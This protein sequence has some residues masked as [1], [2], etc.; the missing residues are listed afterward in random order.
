VSPNYR[1]E[2]SDELDGIFKL[3]STPECAED[4]DV[5]LVCL[6]VLK[7]LSRKQENR[8]NFGRKGLNAV[9]RLLIDPKSNRVAGR[10]LHSFP[11]PLNLSL[12]CP[13]PLNCSSL[14]PPYDPN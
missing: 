14:C 13:F 8:K 9:L 3:M 4:E 6:K 5:S 12:P 2:R 11:F 7:I 10:G 1:D